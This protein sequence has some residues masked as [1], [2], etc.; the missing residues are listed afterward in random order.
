MATQFSLFFDDEFSEDQRPRL[1]RP[2]RANTWQLTSHACRRCFGRV[3]Q[4]VVEGEVSEVRCAECG[5]AASGPVRMLC[6]CGADC[7]ALGQ[8]LECYRNPRVTDQ[9]PH[10]VL[11]RARDEAT[12]AEVPEPT[13]EAVKSAAGAGRDATLKPSSARDSSTHDQAS[14]RRSSRAVGS[15][16]GPARR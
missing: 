11:V 9:N 10:E 12:P 2:R 1:K 5:L 8:A 13:Q 4:R 3:L 14:V 16:R 15:A 7:G 6:V